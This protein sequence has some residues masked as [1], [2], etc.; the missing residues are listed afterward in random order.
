MYETLAKRY[1][2]QDPRVVFA[3]FGWREENGETWESPFQ[4][5]AEKAKTEQWDFDRLEFKKPGRSFPIIANY[6]NFT[7]LRLQQQ[8]KIRY[9]SDNTK[10]CINTGLQTPE[11]KDIFATFYRNQNA[12]ERNQ[13]DWILFG[14]FDGYSDKMREF[15]PLPDIATYIDD[16]SEL[17]FNH[18]FELEVDYKHILNDNRERLPSVL[19]GN[20]ALA[21]NAVEGAVRQL[22]ERLKRNYK[23]A[24]PHWYDERIQLL[25]P[26]CITDDNIA[27]VALVAERDVQRKKYMVRTVLT[28]DMAYVDARIICAPDRQ[29]LNP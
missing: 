28:M 5:L 29:W 9:S 25:L 20:P 12:V 23:L 14:Y 1:K 7:F 15:E 18:H 6:L 21:R 13:T 26:L 22:K 8:S 11:G 19:Q 17:V 24:V 16:P 10:A 27:D 2:E 4:K 3:Y